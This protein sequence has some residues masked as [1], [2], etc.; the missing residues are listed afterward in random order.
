MSAVGVRRLAQLGL[1]GRHGPGCLGL[2]LGEED[3]ERLRGGVH[4]QVGQD[5]GL[6]AGIVG[7][8]AGRQRPLGLR[9]ARVAE[10]LG[11]RGDQPQAHGAERLD[12]RVV[13][14]G[15]LEDR[16][17]QPIGDELGYRIP[18]PGVAAGIGIRQGTR[19]PESLVRV[20]LRIFEH[21]P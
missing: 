4:E 7:Q 1:E 9:L 5:A 19:R 14:A 6:V 2:D 8:D 21:T 18:A 12:Q 3:R 17:Q 16:R 13:M 15:V 10:G 11:Q 20:G